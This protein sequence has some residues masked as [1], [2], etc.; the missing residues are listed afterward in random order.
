VARRQSKRLSNV[1][2]LVKDLPV[3]MQAQHRKDDSHNTAFVVGFV[4]AGL[5]G[6]ALVLWKTPRSG[7]A[8]R[9]LIAEK[10]ESGLFHTLGMD[11]YLT[12]EKIP[13]SLRGTFGAAAETSSNGVANAGAAAGPT[14]RHASEDTEPIM[15]GSLEA[16]D[17]ATLPV[18]Y[19]GKP[20]TETIAQSG[21]QYRSS[22]N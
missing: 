14:G 11:K 15:R 20:L 5:A 22:A 21:S 12:G 6:A 17:P 16:E 1:S 19:R 2:D 18:T 13:T 7:S 10:T 8:M 3:T 9:E 4:L